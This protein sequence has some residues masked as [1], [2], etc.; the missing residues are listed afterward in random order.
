MPS[1]L[2]FEREGKT[3]LPKTFAYDNVYINVLDSES[4]AEDQVE[5]FYGIEDEFQL[6]PY[7]SPLPTPNPRPKW[8]QKVIETAGNMT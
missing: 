6:D 3:I 1:Q 2:L 7:P 5:S 4:E 8:S